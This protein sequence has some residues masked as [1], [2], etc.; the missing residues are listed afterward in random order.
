M[1]DHEQPIIV[2]DYRFDPTREQPE[3]PPEYGGEDAPAADGYVIIQFRAALTQE[4]R[5]RVQGEYGLELTDYIP[6]FAYLERISQGNLAA[7]SRDPAVRA[8]VPYLPIFKVSSGIGQLVKRS[9]ERQDMAGL[10]VRL[11]LFPTA[12]PEQVANQLRSLGATEARVFDDR[13]LGG[14]ARIECVIPSRDPLP[15]IAQIP[16]VRWIE[17]VPE[18]I[19]D[20][21]NTAGTMQSGTPGTTPIWNQGLRGE[22][23][24]IGVLDS[25]ALDMNHCWFEDNVNN[26]PNPAHRKVVGFRNASGDGAGGHATFVA[27]IVAG[28]D[29]NNLGAAANRGNAFNARLTYGN[30]GD[31]SS[32]TTLLA[33]LNAAAADGAFIHTNSWHQ[34]PTP[35]Y[36]QDAA[37]VDTFVWNNEDHLVLGSSGNVG[38]S[39]GPP[40]TAKN[41]LCVSATMQDPNEMSFGDGNNGPTPDGRRKP[42]IFAPGC[43]ITSSTSGTACGTDT[44][45][46]ATSWATPATAAAAALVRQYFTEGWYPT[47]TL[48]PSNAFEPS[49]ALMKAT[50]L[51]STIDMTGI[52][53]YPGNQEG[54]GLLQLN[55]VLFFSGGARN[56][57]VW[58]NRNADG[59]TTGVSRT[60]HVDV[61]TNAQPLKITLVWSD[62]PAAAGSAA[63]VVNDLDLT[64]TSP[65]GTQVFRGNNFAAGVSATGG[66]ADTL[67]N[68]EMVLVNN[69]APGDWT[70]TVTATAVNVGNPGQGYAVAA[71]GDFVEAPSPIGIQDTLIVRVKFSDIAFKPPLP[72]LQNT[73]A[74]VADYI[75]EVSYGQTTLRPRFRGPITLSQPKSYYFHPSRNPLIELTEE[76]V[77]ELIALDPNIFDTGTA[78]D[79]E[80]MIIVTNDVNFTGDWATT[81]QW[82][83]AD[84]GGFT[85]PISVSIQSYAN[86]VARFTHGFL[87]QLGMVDLYA[88]E[89]VV[90]PRPYV[91]E[92]D[93]MA[94]LFTNVHPLVWEKQRPGWVTGHGS[95]IT[96]IPRPAAGTSYTGPSPI[97][98]F[99]QESTAQN[100]KAIALGLTEGAGMMAQE[101]VFYFIEARSNTLGG[102]DD[103]LPGTGVLIYYVNEL[104][105]QG[106]G[107]VILQDRSPGTNTLADAFFRVGDSRTI[108]GTGITIT[109][110][111]G[112][113]GAAFDIDLAYT[114]PITDYNLSITKGETLNGQFVYYYSPDIWVDSPKNGFNL[115]AGPP[116]HDQREHPVIGMVNRIYARV[117]NAGPGTAFD[118]DVRFRISEPVH[119]IG[120]EEDFDTFIG[121]KHVD[122]LGVGDAIVFTEWTPSGVGVPHSCV[123]VDL[124]NLVGT[125]T[126]EYDHEA[127]ENLDE[128]TSVTASPFHAVDYHYELTNPY[129]QEALFYFRAEGAP[130]DW[131]VTLNPPKI[132][133]L[134]GER[135][136]GVATIQPPEHA[137]VCTSELVQITSWTPRGDTI[138]P[139]GG[140]AVQ[141]DLRKRTLLTLDVD[142]GRCGGNE[143]EILIQQAKEQGQE[144]TDNLISKFKR[145]CGTVT[146]QGCT[147]PPQPNQEI[148][149]KFIDPLGNP[150][151]HTVMTDENG[152]FE[153]MLVTVTDGTWQ[154]EA[155]YPGDKCQAPVGPVRETVCRCR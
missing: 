142:T 143:I 83:Y 33:Y 89:N 68:V 50:L 48:E 147:D 76:V 113:G 128:V 34:E 12:D 125:D 71:S 30:N 44:R 59:L 18:V 63:P 104:I 112:T 64:V 129:E 62:P 155:E 82:P 41:A 10:L 77:A 24:I 21:G 106:Q 148:I 97:R 123:L 121:I 84:P 43:N 115:G 2:G 49:G 87:H 102:F 122:S 132:L 116:P 109:V 105:P 96:Y 135:M 22:D 117:H 5:E 20:N 111:A 107:P 7:V 152:C 67:N 91:D 150:V 100:R 94:G 57:R 133:L 53:G 46:C 3:V 120:G 52:A 61:A 101:N 75:E 9:K 146:A 23:Q 92:W 139:V 85:R 16:G 88:H 138:I 26:T 14:I 4:E 35:Q 70:I 131:A 60:H 126:N 80:R 73:I 8:V 144:I 98:L 79:I 151:Y 15:E 42:E 39:I 47:G 31:L 103:G 137:E 69:P 6:E 134:P 56:L 154:V 110:Q 27:G 141:V 54:W 127:Q 114:P 11:V 118:F 72:N 25:R 17:E 149:V 108:P 29:V 130:A 40:G 99:F 93:N 38:E 13:E 28:D 51:N 32:T 66:A 78:N 140:A 58:E 1:A 37:D 55:R 36:S 19:E 90:F 86:P 95:E 136:A 65:D 81:G 124:I 74:E 119:T 145:K 153:D 45:G